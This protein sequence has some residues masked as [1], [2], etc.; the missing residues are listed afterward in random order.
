M[1]LTVVPRTDWSRSPSVSFKLMCHSLTS[2]LVYH[3]I[4]FSWF[5]GCEGIRFRVFLEMIFGPSVRESG[6]AYS[7]TCFLG[8]P[9]SKS[10]FVYSEK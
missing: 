1:A 3:E 2:A 7:E 10:V 8:P 9:V 5:F 4:C 6:F